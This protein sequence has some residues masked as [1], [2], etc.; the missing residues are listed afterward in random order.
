[1]GQ[2]LCG[3][4]ILQLPPHYGFPLS[5]CTSWQQ[6]LAQ[7]YGIFLEKGG[8][9]ALMDTWWE[10][11]HRTDA[12]ICKWV[13]KYAIGLLVHEISHLTDCTNDGPHK[14]LVQH[15]C[16]GSGQITKNKLDAFSL[17]TL[18]DNYDQTLLN[19][20]AVLTALMEN[21]HITWQNQNDELRK[22]EPWNILLVDVLLLNIEY[23]SLTVVLR[24]ESWLPQPFSIYGAAS[25]I[26]IRLW[27]PLFCGTNRC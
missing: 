21:Q 4:L 6:R 23:L 5:D 16:V 11:C 27:T 25:Q 13:I 9:I 12:E 8:Q 19:L 15:L 26:Y 14:E 2:K 7:A 3:K 1:M 24:H 22:R 17:A 20:Q 10:K 18:K